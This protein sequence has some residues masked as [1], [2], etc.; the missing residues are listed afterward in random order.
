MIHHYIFYKPINISFNLNV[1]NII[2][3]SFKSLELKSYKGFLRLQDL[4]PSV[5]LLTYPFKVPM[6]IPLYLLHCPCEEEEEE[7]IE[8]YRVMEPFIDFFS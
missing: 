1:N 6:T 7:D 8:E 3:K 4:L 5:I 2:F